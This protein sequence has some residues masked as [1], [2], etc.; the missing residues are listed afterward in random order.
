MWSECCLSG[1]VFSVY[2]LKSLLSKPRQQWHW[3]CANTWRLITKRR[4]R[5]FSRFTR[6]CGFCRF[7]FHGNI[8]LLLNS[9][10]QNLRSLE[11]ISCL[12]LLKT[13]L[14]SSLT[15]LWMRSF[16]AVVCQLKEQQLLTIPLW[17]PHPLINAS[18]MDLRLVVKIWKPEVMNRMGHLYTVGGENI[19]MLPHKFSN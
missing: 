18:I 9:W 12:L 1:L 16:T 15:T 4:F 7:C 2:S 10:D 14:L 19:R 3:V 11:K 17:S 13:I 6:F 8:D 5:A